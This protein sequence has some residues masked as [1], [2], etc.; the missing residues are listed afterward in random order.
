MAGVLVLAAGVPTAFETYNFTIITF[1]YVI[2][3]IA[4]IA[5]WLRVWFE[6]PPGR[7]AALRYA[8]GDRRVPDRLGAPA[9][10]SRTR[11]T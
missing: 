9:C 4:M 11:G 1:G 3:R 8:V 5:Q 6:Y 2:M 10:S 7:P